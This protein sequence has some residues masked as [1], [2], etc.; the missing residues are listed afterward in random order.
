MADPAAAPPG[1]KSML[2]NTK[3]EAA[4]WEEICRVH[5]NSFTSM[6]RPAVRLITGA[7]LVEGC[8]DEIVLEYQ[9]ASAVSRPNSQ[10]SPPLSAPSS[11]LL[12]GSPS[13]RASQSLRILDNACGLAGSITVALAV[14]SSRGVIRNGKDIQ[15]YASDATADRVQNVAKTLKAAKLDNVTFVPWPMEVSLRSLIVVQ[16][17]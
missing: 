17:V 10:N 2:A 7:G 1:V 13:L 11:P 12:S 15:I 8:D 6:S 14:L 16:P 5:G 3:L 9:P 4:I